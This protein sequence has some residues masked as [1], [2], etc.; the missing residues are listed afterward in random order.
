LP[1]DAAVERG[2]DAQLAPQLD[3]GVGARNV[4]ETGTIQGAD[5]H[6]FDR[7]GLDRKIGRPCPADGEKSR[8]RAKD[9][10]S[11][12]H[13]MI[14]LISSFMRVHVGSLVTEKFPERMTRS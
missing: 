2:V 11:N 13:H 4:E 9:E 6:I 1:V 14:P 5:P 10:F 3:A 7:F 8:R 12:R